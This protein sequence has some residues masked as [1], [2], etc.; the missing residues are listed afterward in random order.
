MGNL[1]MITSPTVSWHIDLGKGV[2]RLSQ[3][4][5]FVVTMTRLPARPMGS[6]SETG[7]TYRRSD[8]LD[9]RQSD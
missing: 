1:L 3:R 4:R 5:P 7:G 8:P 9:L 6:G 2:T